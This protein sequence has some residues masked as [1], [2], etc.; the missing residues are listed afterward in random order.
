M[1]EKA[2]KVTEIGEIVTEIEEEA[3]RATEIEG[4]AGKVTEIAEEAGKKRVKTRARARE[5]ESRGAPAAAAATAIATATVRW[6][7][8]C[9]STRSGKRR[10]KRS[11]GCVRSLH[12]MTRTEAYCCK[13]KGP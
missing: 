2:G 5:D 13:I 3:G 12:E 4:E 10:N 8:F 6:R 9:V 11:L 1:A 7:S